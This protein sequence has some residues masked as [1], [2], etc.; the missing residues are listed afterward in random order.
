[1]TNANGQVEVDLATL[2]RDVAH[3]NTMVNRMDQ[4][5]A[6]VV[7]LAKMMAVQEA[8]FE[9]LEHKFRSHEK[10]LASKE[11]Q[12]SAF[13]SETTDA[14][15]Q[16]EDNF[17][18]SQNDFQRQLIEHQDLA[19]TERNALHKEMMQTIDTHKNAVDRLTKLSYYVTGAM[20]VAA[21]SISVLP[22]KELILRLF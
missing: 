14:I 12:D 17:R 8:K 10:I 22:I 20:A 5:L 13:R 6:T 7:D 15:R 19:R 21:F 3:I 2:R 18:K 11:M 16:L 1:M 4:S 9:A